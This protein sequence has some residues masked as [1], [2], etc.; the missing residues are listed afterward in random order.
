MIQGTGRR[1]KAICRVTLTPG[2]GEFQINGLPIAHYMGHR[3]T[4]ID[5]IQ[6]PLVFLEL[7][8]ELDVDAYVHGGGL[9][10]QADAV[11]L[12]VSRALVELRADHRSPL[13]R[14]GCLTVD[15]RTKERKK[16]GRKKARKSPQFSKR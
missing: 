14:K 13:R 2:L 11:H 7:A 5:V 6:T 1:K 12:A 15:A 9:V 10:G 3:Q 16:V 8:H 4:L